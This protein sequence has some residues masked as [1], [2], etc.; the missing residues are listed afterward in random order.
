[1]WEMTAQSSL[2]FRA[3]M[4]ASADAVLLGDPVSYRI[5]WANRAAA[6]A[7]GLPSSEILQRSFLELSSIGARYTERS[8]NGELNRALE[9]DHHIFEWSIRTRN[10]DEFPIEA[11]ATYVK[12]ENSAAAIMIQF[13]DISERKL[14]E[15]NLKRHELRFREFMQ[16]LAEGVC[17]VSCDG[18]IRYFSASASRLLGYEHAHIVGSHL[19][20]LLDS[21]GRRQLQTR[22]SDPS[23]T[24]RVL[25]Y[26]IRHA[27]GSWRWHDANYRY[28]EMEHDLSGF[29]LHFRDI[30]DAI[31][32]EKSAREQERMLEFLARHSAMGEMAAAIAHELSQPLAA[33]QNYIEGALRRLARDGTEHAE[34]MQGLRHATAQVDRATEIVRSVRGYVVKL[35]LPRESLDLN[36]ILSEVR[37]FIELRARQMSVRVTWSLSDT[38]LMVSGERVLIGQVILNL[39]FN[40]IEAMSDLP[41][42]RRLL[43]LSTVAE[44]LH[45]LVRVEDRGR[46]LPVGR[47]QKMF[48]GFFSTKKTGNGIGLSLCQN[49]VSK[50]DGVIWA[51]PAKEAGAVF[52]IKLPL[53]TGSGDEP[54]KPLN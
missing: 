47:E 6:N 36:D 13:R 14:A 15:L 33:T 34:I 28:V 45:A 27:D 18:I 40:A 2:D 53:Q 4:D 30:T 48:S 7:Y 37:Y 25:R 11:S 20:D 26:R 24:V 51:E 19:H 54:L 42:V 29:L 52:F 5:L 22:F 3:L 31:E 8:L 32:A 10:G 9:R 41:A 12:F 39:A 46:G 43:R 16:D 17:I 21:R 49:I 1:M 38:P 35:E 23:P 50:H 44:G